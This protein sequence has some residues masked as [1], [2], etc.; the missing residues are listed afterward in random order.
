M[1][2]KVA[3]NVRGKYVNN[4]RQYEQALGASTGSLGYD[5]WDLGWTG[6]L[7]VFSLENINAHPGVQWYWEKV[8]AGPD[9]KEG[10]KAFVCVPITRKECHEAYIQSAKDRLQECQ[11]QLQRGGGQRNRLEL[12]IKVYQ[13]LIQQEP[14]KPDLPIQLQV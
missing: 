14:N 7:K 4:S 11:D 5:N 2:K 9:Q 8:L 10:W 1:A 13:M 6:A 3:W 12:N